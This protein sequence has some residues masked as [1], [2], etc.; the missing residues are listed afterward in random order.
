MELIIP[1]RRLVLIGTKAMDGTTQAK[2]DGS[3]A[4][5]DSSLARLVSTG[6][7]VGRLVAGWPPPLWSGRLFSRLSV[8][9][10]KTY[11]ATL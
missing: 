3:S 2:G 7:L 11:R 4:R 6:S 8:F 5:P 10:A 1:K 9:R